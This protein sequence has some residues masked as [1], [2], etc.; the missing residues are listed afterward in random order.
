MGLPADV[1][2]KLTHEAIVTATYTDEFLLVHGAVTADD[3]VYVL[4]SPQPDELLFAAE[5]LK[6]SLLPEAVPVIDLDV[7]LGWYGNHDNF[8]RDVLLDNIKTVSS[9]KHGRHLAVVPAGVN[10]T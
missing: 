10:V 3:N 8:P 1:V 5:E 9:S 2:N 6:F 7:L 4:H